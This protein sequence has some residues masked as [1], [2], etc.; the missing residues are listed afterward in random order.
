MQA[1]VA[2][3]VEH[4]KSPQAQ[5]PQ[6]Y[7]QVPAWKFRLGQLQKQVKLQSKQGQVQ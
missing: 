2:K 7:Q 3:M 1:T 6:I 4:L 5:A